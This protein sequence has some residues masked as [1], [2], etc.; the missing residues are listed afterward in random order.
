MSRVRSLRN[1]QSGFTEIGLVLILGIIIAGSI[2]LADA[3]RDDP[4]DKTAFVQAA[5]QDYCS[6]VPD[7][8]GCLQR[9][10]RQPQLTRYCTR[11]IPNRDELSFWEPDA[12]EMRAACVAR[13]HGWSLAFA[14]YGAIEHTADKWCDGFGP[15]LEGD[16][17]RELTELENRMSRQIDE[18][19]LEVEKRVEAG[20]EQPPI[21]PSRSHAE[22]ACPVPPV[23][24][25]PTPDS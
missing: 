8:D 14:R 7:E 6:K 15:T 12:Q 24:V 13:G 17:F 3:L 1:D 10:F 21:L 2:A 11:E 16:E 25:P 20:L 18:Y 4:P 23:P 22:P 9:D 19:A 5:K